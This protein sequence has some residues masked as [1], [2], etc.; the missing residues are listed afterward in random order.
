MSIDDT[1][2]QGIHSRLDAQVA[3]HNNS[4]FK[5]NGDYVIQEPQKKERISPLVPPSRLQEDEELGQGYQFLSEFG[6]GIHT[7]IRYGRHATP[8]EL[9]DQSYEQQV[10]DADIYLLEGLGWTK[11]LQEGLDFLADT[12]ESAQDNRDVQDFVQ[13]PFNRR[14]ADAIS[15]T[16]TRVSFFDVDNEEGDELRSG[17]IEQGDVIYG[18][19]GQGSEVE[20]AKIIN[21][22][23]F[24][25]LREWFMVG[26]FGQQIASLVEKDPDLLQKL[27]LGQLKVLITIGD[28][29]R[30]LT[31]KLGQFGVRVTEEVILETA[32]PSNRL[33][34]DSIKMG[35]ING[36]DLERVA[37]EQ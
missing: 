22:V 1:A 10:S 25:S 3:W 27:S 18:I 21:T 17:M 36:Q 19:T 30:N 26:Q 37:N 23:A 15:G 31:D 20:K 4:F 8:E 9:G 13:Y 34:T 2:E 24:E 16:Q 6:Q 32:N 28:T 33:V 5:E 14:I 7:H 35:K 11:N 29:H 12:G